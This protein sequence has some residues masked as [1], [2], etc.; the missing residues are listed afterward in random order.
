MALYARFGGHVHPRHQ[1]D[2]VDSPEPAGG[3]AY[4][5]GKDRK[6]MA[7]TAKPASIN[8][9][10]ASRSAQSDEFGR[11]A[12]FRRCSGTR[13]LLGGVPSC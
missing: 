4:D 3:V 10:T 9:D 2:G 11:A 8:F 5:L 13:D 7:I 12:G 6:A 1:H